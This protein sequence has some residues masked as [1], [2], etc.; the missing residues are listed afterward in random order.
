MRR[1]LAHQ[2]RRPEHAV[3]AGRDA[4]RFI[5]EAFVCG[6]CRSIGVSSGRAELIAEPAQRQTGRL[7]HAHHVPAARDRVTERVDPPLGIERGTIGRGEDDAGRADRR[8]D[9]ARAA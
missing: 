9:G 1:P 7:R 6:V 8:A 2:V 3:R 4:R 5:D